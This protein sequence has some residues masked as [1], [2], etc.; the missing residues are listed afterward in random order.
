VVSRY[1]A[2]DGHA[3]APASF[4]KGGMGAL[5]EALARA[6]QAAG[7]EIRTGA[8]VAQIQVDKGEATAVMLAGGE[9]LP[10]RAVVSNADPRHTFLHLVDPAK[11]D[12]EFLIKIRNYR[13]L[14][15]AAKVNLALAGLPDFTALKRSDSN[16]RAELSGRI[17]IG[18][19]IDYLERAFDAAKYGDYSPEAYM[20]ITIPSFTDPTLAPEGK[21]VMSIYVQY[22]PYHLKDGD[23]TT[24]REEFGDAVIK[25][26]SAYAPNLDNL[27]IHRQVIT[28]SDLERT[29]GL[30]G[31]HV[32][33]GEPSLDQ[34]FAFRPLIGWAQYRSPVKRLYLCGAG[35]HPGGGVTGAPGAN[36]S[37]EITRDLKAA[38]RS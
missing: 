14:G 15:S 22:A 23:W 26:L 13:S 16:G 11:F 9:E 37:R 27:I 7:A 8:E 20:D 28:P 35:T 30:T 25:S 33:H 6:A 31:G 38:R 18:P 29:Y 21:H 1:A 4:I 12:P 24:R 10:A 3:V 2:L 17:H 5:T 32:L 36:A 34:L 19:N